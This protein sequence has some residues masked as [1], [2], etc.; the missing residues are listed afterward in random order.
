MS[1]TVTIDDQLLRA[2]KRIAAQRGV[3]LSEVIE[4]ALR[5][6]VVDKP[7]REHRPFK[8]ITFRGDGVRLGIDLDRASSLE[9]ADD[10][11]RYTTSQS[12]CRPYRNR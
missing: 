9:L 10:I 11:E 3:T 2:A 1:T 6:L 12:P 7:A 8:L 4:N 5:T